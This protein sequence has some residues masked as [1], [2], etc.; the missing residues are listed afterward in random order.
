MAA[1]KGHPK[2]K[3]RQAGTPNKAKT[4]PICTAKQADGRW[5]SSGCGERLPY[6]CRKVPIGRTLDCDCTGQ[7]DDDDAGGSCKAWDVSKPCVRSGRPEFGIE[8]E[9]ARDNTQPHR[10][11]HQAGLTGYDI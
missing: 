10:L 2:W 6:V 1:P 11:E 5:I 7:V 4:G 9:H 8:M 3:G